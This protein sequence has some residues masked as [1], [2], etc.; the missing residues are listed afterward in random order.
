VTRQTKDVRR[1]YL[2]PDKYLT[3]EEVQRLLRFVKIG[4]DRARKQGTIRGLVNEMII[5]LMLETGVRSEELCH[6]ILSDLPTHHGKNAILIRKKKGQESR[7]VAVYPDLQKKLEVY[8]KK[9][10]PGAKPG[11]PLFAC[12]QGYR[13][14]RT[15]IKK[16][17]KWVIIKENTSRIS[18]RSLY[19]R[20]KRISRDAKIPHLRP[21]S[22][23]H[24]LGTHLYS[25]ERD[26]AVV[27]KI[28]GHKSL[29]ST[30]VYIGV[31]DDSVIRQIGK[32]KQ[33]YTVKG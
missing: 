26:I 18:Y 21:H 11:S 9:C 8:I 33:L 31:S 7:V 27:G 12:E 4:A 28:L 19:R 25:V 15:R 10:R 20:I 16:N 2:K 17:N 23:R 22:L 1:D 32:I 13:L 30:Q 29:Q 14:L 3:I 6:L 24:T 5:L